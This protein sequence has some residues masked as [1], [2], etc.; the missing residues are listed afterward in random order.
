MRGE[1]AIDY[2]CLWGYTVIGTDERSLIS[3]VRR[4]VE[5]NKYT[6]NLS[7]KSERGRYCSLRLSVRVNSQEERKDIY[8]RLGEITSVRAVL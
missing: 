7:K 8:N 5:N 3:A 1:V 6:I 4:V 2:P